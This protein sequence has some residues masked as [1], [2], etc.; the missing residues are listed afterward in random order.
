LRIKDLYDESELAKYTSTTL[1]INISII[2]GNITNGLD[3]INRIQKHIGQPFGDT[4]MKV[5]YIIF[6]KI[7]QK[8]KVCLSGDGADEV[9]CGYILRRATLLNNLIT[10]KMLRKGKMNRVIKEVIVK[11]ITRYLNNTKINLNE[12]IKESILKNYNDYHASNVYREV[13]WGLGETD[14]ILNIV[15]WILIKYNLPNDMLVKVDRTSMMNS[16]EVRVPFLN[17]DVVEQ[18][19]LMSGK[20]KQ[21]MMT[22]KIILREMLKKSGI[23]KK[24]LNK[25]KIG[26]GPRPQ[27]WSYLFKG[28]PKQ[29]GIINDMINV[30]DENM[31]RENIYYLLA[32]NWERINESGGG[33]AE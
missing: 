14:D 2:N 32:D 8:Y 22:T 10:E 13:E 26:F 24:Y 23:S 9:F 6:N 21:D 18:G 15:S 5:A 16:L 7:A 29:E 33:D 28:M 3:V 17:H 25:P 11:I 12:W 4:S 27:N 1:G 19:L 30:R 20:T 31:K